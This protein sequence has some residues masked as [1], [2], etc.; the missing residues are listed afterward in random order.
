MMIKDIVDSNA[1]CNCG[2]CVSACPE[3]AIELDNSFLPRI[4]DNCT[5][6]GI[7]REVCPRVDMPFSFIADSL[8]KDNKINF[9]EEL[10]GN[11]NQIFLARMSDSALREKTYCGGSTTAFLIYLL[12]KGLIDK[13]LLTGKEHN[14]DFC[15]HPKPMEA[16]TKEEILACAYTKPTAN[17]ILSKLPVKGKK[18]AIV[19]TPCHVQGIRKAQYLAKFGKASKEK[20]RELVGNIEFVI[21]LNCFFA[22]KKDGVDYL[23]SKVGLKEE[24]LKKFYNWKGKSVAILN[25]GQ[26]IEDFGEGSDFD[27]LNLGCLLCYPSYSAKLSD[28]TFGKCMIEEWGQNDVISRSEKADRVLKEMI[29]NKIL[30]VQP[31][32]DEKSEILEGLL[33]AN[34]FKYDSIGYGEFLKTGRFATTNLPGGS[35]MEK[36]SSGSIKGIN[37]LRLIQ[38]VKRDSFYEIVKQERKKSG[39]FMPEMK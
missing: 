19:G 22:F 14:L 31:L 5:L 21:G 4:L 3:K 2:L 18:V 16:S 38:A 8:K 34:V 6:C 25:N 7:C 39:I 37:R 24:D 13:A 23:L 33:E 36:G 15:G 17:P 9:G 29:D 35:P 10:L 32:K 12:E 26:K 1:C 30:E 27:S 20:C 28:I 11:Y